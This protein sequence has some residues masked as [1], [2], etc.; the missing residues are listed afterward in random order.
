LLLS[1][2]LLA[3][4]DPDELEAVVEHERAHVA[5]RENLKRFVLRA[6]PDPLAFFPAGA[7]LRAA[8]EAAA[9]EAA[10]QAACARVPPLVLARTLLKVAA[11]VPPGRPIEMAAAALHREDMLEGRVR[12]LIA[13][14]EGP[15]LPAP[16]VARA[17]LRSPWSIGLLGLAALATFVSATALPVVHRLLEGLVHL[18]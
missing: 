1:E 5:A 3:A 17:S 11:L 18:F 4:L 16:S 12:A 8:F 2:S 14:A 15:A 13:H 7:R 6:S 9:E 10:D